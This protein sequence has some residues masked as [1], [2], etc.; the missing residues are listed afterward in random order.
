MIRTASESYEAQ[1]GQEEEVIAKKQD[2]MTAA[3]KIGRW[4][5]DTPDDVTQIGPDTTLDQDDEENEEGYIIAHFP[6]AWIF[7]TRSHA[8]QWLLSR[9]RAEVLLTRIKGSRAE[10]IKSEILEALASLPRTYEYGQAVKTCRF[11]IDWDLSGFLKEKYINEDGLQLGSLITIVGSGEDVQALTCAEYLTQVW[12]TT[13]LET[14]AALQ[15]AL[16][17]GVGQI[18]NGKLILLSRNQD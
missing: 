12:P 10:T 3:E 9:M 11:D 2:E 5:V 16:N 13:G 6:D 15:G 17:N 8:Y 1:G 4:H 14:L 7:L 18:F